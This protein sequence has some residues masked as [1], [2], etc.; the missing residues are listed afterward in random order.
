VKVAPLLVVLVSSIAHA[1][2]TAEV[3]KLG[4]LDRLAMANRVVGQNVRLAIVK[5]KWSG[6]LGQQRRA[7][8]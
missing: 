1:Q 6:N 8:G 5:P 4:G 7:A 2:L 3:N